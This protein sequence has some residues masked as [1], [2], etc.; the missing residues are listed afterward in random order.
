MHLPVYSFILLSLN[1]VFHL[2][3]AEAGGHEAARSHIQVPLLPALVVR[4]QSINPPIQGADD[5]QRPADRTN[6]HTH[7]EKRQSSLRVLGSFIASCSM[8]SVISVSG[9]LGSATDSQRVCCPRWRRRESYQRRPE[10]NQT[11]NTIG[12]SSALWLKSAEVYFRKTKEKTPII[13]LLE[14]I[15]DGFSTYFMLAQTPQAAK[16][17][18][19]ELSLPFR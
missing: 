15:L 18:L 12:A 4:I 16:N 13:I 6:K 14:N 11:H 5:H 7:G 9:R 2:W 8:I 10:N 1:A 19:Q 3:F 17:K